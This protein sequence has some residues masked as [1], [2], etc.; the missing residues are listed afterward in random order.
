MEVRFQV[1]P[2]IILPVDGS[3]GKLLDRRQITIAD[4]GYGEIISIRG[5]DIVDYQAELEDSGYLFKMVAAANRKTRPI[6]MLCGRSI[7]YP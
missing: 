6:A 2:E 5:I 1:H 7:A 4:L 3:N